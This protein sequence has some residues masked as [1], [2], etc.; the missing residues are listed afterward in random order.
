LIVIKD[1]VGLGSEELVQLL[2]LENL[3][4][5]P[6]LIDGGLS[7][8]ISDTS[9]GDEGEEGEVEFPEHGL[10]EHEEGEASVGEEGS[11]PAI[12]RSVQSLVNLVQVVSTSESPFLEIVL[13]DEVAVVELVRVSLG[14]VLNKLI[15]S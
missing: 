12:V 4:E 9:E 8:L 15:W 14:F 1:V 10:V 11:S 3:I 6:H 5:D 13:E 7:T 2:V